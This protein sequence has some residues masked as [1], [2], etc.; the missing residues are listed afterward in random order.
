MKDLSDLTPGEIWWVHFE[1]GEGH[2]RIETNTWPWHKKK[3]D[4]FS[5]LLLGVPRALRD[6]V[7]RAM[8]ILLG[9]EDSLGLGNQLSSNSARM[10]V[11][12]PS[13]IQ[14]RAR[15]Y[16]AFKNLKYELYITKK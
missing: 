8:Q 12:H 13:N 9:G 6:K 10:P 14:G 7:S 5:I 4:P 15:P 2:A 16:Y 1:V 3:L 11:G